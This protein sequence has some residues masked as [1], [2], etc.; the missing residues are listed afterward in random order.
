LLAWVFPAVMVAVVLATG[1][2]YL[3]DVVGSA[4]LLAASITV[5]RLWGHLIEGGRTTTDR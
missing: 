1:A 3:L 5:A 2:H 4:V